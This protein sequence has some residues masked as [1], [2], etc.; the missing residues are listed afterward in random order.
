[1]SHRGRAS[2]MRRIEARL[3]FLAVSTC[4]GLQV[5]MELACTWSAAQQAAVSDTV[6][7]SI[8]VK[9]PTSRPLGHWP[10]PKHPTQPA[11]C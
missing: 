9:Q 11:T 8:I 6:P 7:Q 5:Q 1:M 3:R 4:C 10:V 2:V